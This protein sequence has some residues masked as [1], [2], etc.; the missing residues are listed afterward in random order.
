MNITHSYSFILICS[1]LGNRIEN[2]PDKIIELKNLKD[3]NFENNPISE[4]PY[5]LSKLSLLKRINFSNTKIQS[6]ENFPFDKFTDLRYLNLSYCKLTN[7][8]RNISGCTKLEELDLCGNQLKRIPKEIGY[9]YKSLNKLNLSD[10]KLDKLPGE[11]NMLDP[12]IKLEL[13]GN[14]LQHPFNLYK[15]SIIELFDALM[16]HCKAHGFSCVCEGEGLRTATKKK[17]TSFTIIAKDY[18]GRDRINGGDHFDVSIIKES[19]DDI[20][21]CD[22][23]IKDHKNGKYEVFYNPLQGG[24]YRIHV[25]CE[26]IP[27]K[28]SP[29]KLIVFES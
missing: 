7:F 19:D 25:S 14:N 21:Q 13:D 29:F 16:A 23:T 24:E 11:I 4:L 26:S 15:N 20:Y 6:T 8:S 1:I 3:I 5:I 17:G 28:D 22:V 27:L 12:S 9:L 10:N 18:I 2:I